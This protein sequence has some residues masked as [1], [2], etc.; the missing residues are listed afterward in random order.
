MK[1]PN[2]V[3][4]FMAASIFFSTFQ[5][6]H[7]Q[8]APGNINPLKEP[9]SPT[10]PEVNDAA[11]TD[12]TPDLPQSKP[13]P[14]PEVRIFLGSGA[15]IE[16]K[17]EMPAQFVIKHTIDGLQYEKN[18]SPADLL[19]IEILTYRIKDRRELNEGKIFYEFEPDQV[20][21]TLRNGRQYFFT[22]IFP[23]LRKLEVVTIDG[24]TTLYT[25][26]GDTF[27]QEKGWEQVPNRDPA[28][29][30]N[31]PHPHSVVRIRFKAN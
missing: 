25:Y 23:F 28:S 20:K 29:H 22:T 26:F 27:D 1:R 21:V 10:E 9:I 24:K 4:I 5:P 31:K 7:S 12:R 17:I 14:L 30:Q 19:E 18:V 2:P 15:M 3:L 16:G 8:V 6:A 11:S 13:E